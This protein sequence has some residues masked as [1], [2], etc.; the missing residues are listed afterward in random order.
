MTREQYRQMQMEALEN[1]K[2]D[3]TAHRNNPLL[4][5]TMRQ[6]LEQQYEAICRKQAE[7]EKGVFWTPEKEKNY[8]EAY[9][10]MPL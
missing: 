1:L 10:D 3:V 4:L 6:A 7:W 8:L 2:A 5:A 9:K